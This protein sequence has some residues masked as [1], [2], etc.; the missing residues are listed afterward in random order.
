MARFSI[1]VEALY[2]LIDMLH[3]HL[4]GDLCL[5]EHSKRLIERQMEVVISFL[6]E[7]HND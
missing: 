6:A 5:S 4:N 2:F 1:P 3:H 7:V